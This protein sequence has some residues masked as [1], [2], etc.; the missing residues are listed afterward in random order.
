MANRQQLRELKVEDALLY[1]D[2]VK[3]EF[4]D[5]PEIYNEFLEIM[6]SFKSQQIDTPG[7]IRRVST[8]FEGYGKLIYGFNTFLPEGY[9]IDVPEHLRDQ[10]RGEIGAKPKNLLPLPPKRAPAPRKAP[11]ARMPPPAPVDE[12]PRQPVEFDNAI[13]YVTAIKKRFEHQPETYK[14][15]LEVLHTYQREQKGIQEVLRRVAELFKDHADL[16]REFTYF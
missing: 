16:L 6:K 3:A 5:E 13:A 7:V 11:P 14:A 8:L 4:G 10:L 12:P 9:K 15:F 1:L 2:Q